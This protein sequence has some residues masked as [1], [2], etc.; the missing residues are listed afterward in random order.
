MPDGVPGDVLGCEVLG[1][2]ARD[3]IPLHGLDLEE[4]R[5]GVEELVQQP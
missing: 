3:Y 4:T 5:Q 1:A 2:E